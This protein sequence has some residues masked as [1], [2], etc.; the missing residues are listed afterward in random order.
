MSIA[1]TLYMHP[2]GIGATTP[3]LL[4]PLLLPPCLAPLGIVVGSPLS[5]LTPL[6]PGCRLGW[7][8]WSARATGPHLPAGW[9]QGVGGRGLVGVGLLLLLLL[10]LSMMSV[11]VA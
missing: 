10:L 1:P 5:P 6:T 3:R 2:L 4:I 9:G 7:E 11:A 8:G